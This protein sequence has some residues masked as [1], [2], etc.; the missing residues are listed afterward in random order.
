M[1]RVGQRINNFR[2]MIERVSP[3]AYQPAIELILVLS[4]YLVSDNNINNINN[5]VSNIKENFYLDVII[6]YFDQS[7]SSK[8]FETKSKYLEKLKFL[9]VV[10]ERDSL[11]ILRLK[12]RDAP[13]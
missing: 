7:I 5:I 2:V 6:G 10:L 1:R 9:L 4:Y 11:M 12:V 13:I 8:A 3:L